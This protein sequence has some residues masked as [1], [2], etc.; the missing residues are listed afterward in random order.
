MRN[1]LKNGKHE[2]ILGERPVENKMVTKI[3]LSTLTV[4]SFFCFTLETFAQTVLVHNTQEEILASEG[5]IKIKYIRTW[6]GDE[7]EDKHKFFRSVSYMTIDKDNRVF[8]G[9]QYNHIIKVFKYSGEYI[10]TIGRRGRGPGDLYSPKGINLSP[11]GDIVVLD[12]VGRRIQI[13]K[14]NGHSLKI[15]KLE[16]LRGQWIGI[17]K[18][19]NFFIYSD[20][21][22][23]NNKKLLQCFDSKGEKISDLGVYHDLLPDYRLSERLKFTMDDQDNIYALNTFAPVIRKYSPDGKLIM[24][25]T[26]EPYIEVPIKVTLNDKKDEIHRVED[27]KNMETTKE[28]KSGN[29]IIIDTSAKRRRSTG[30]GG[31]SVDA[32]NRI[33]TIFLRRRP[34]IKKL[35]HYGIMGNEK[36]FKVIRAKE[37]E[38]DT[39]DHFTLAVFS[40]GGKIIATG[41]INNDSTTFYLKGRKLFI[42]NT[43][44]EKKIDEY[45]IEFVK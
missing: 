26:Y 4:V 35:G 14:H 24:A 17:S 15:I 23:F 44:V 5:K 22:T 2:T 45:E 20:Y 28:T 18:D 38:T 31:I 16:N 1:N 8:I 42:L 36:E 9:D 7:E 41:I 30:R 32:E 37:P 11:M 25:I 34:D 21:W 29:S 12:N 10:R 43:Y 27:I 13:F 40:P 39:F 19:N 33:Y 6:G 3:L